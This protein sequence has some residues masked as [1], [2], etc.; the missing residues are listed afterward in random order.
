L[1]VMFY[2]G[3]IQSR[4]LKKER[5]VE[6]ERQGERKM[7][8]QTYEYR[9]RLSAKR[10]ESIMKTRK[11]IMAI[12]WAETFERRKVPEQFKIKLEELYER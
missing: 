7:R 12:K 5:R 11:E 9:D 8:K 2:F 1:F 4:L 3:Q 10:K 6:K